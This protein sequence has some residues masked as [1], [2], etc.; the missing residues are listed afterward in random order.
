MKMIETLI[1][2]RYDSRYS[3]SSS[4]MYL[5]MM[6][7]NHYDFYW[8]KFHSLVIIFT[9]WCSLSFTSN[10]IGA[11]SQARRSLECRD[12]AV[13]LDCR[14]GFVAIYPNEIMQLLWCN[15][16]LR[17]AT[18]K[19]NNGRRCQSGWRCTRLWRTAAVG[20]RHLKR[21]GESRPVN[22]APRDRGV[23]EVRRDGTMPSEL[24]EEECRH[25]APIFSRAASRRDD[26]R[27]LTIRPIATPAA[28]RTRCLKSIDRLWVIRK[29]LPF[30]ILTKPALNGIKNFHALNFQRSRRTRD[31]PSI[32]SSLF[33]F[34]TGTML[35]R[36]ALYIERKA[37]TCAVNDKICT[38][39]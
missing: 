5:N 20:E 24:S 18:D 33:A 2:T 14:D 17:E 37:D 34:R 25:A 26:K 13:S 15:V 6:C 1:I 28:P 8:V 23:I 29:V 35:T 31:L 16:T 27:R 38:A 32:L 7:K 19:K 39:I 36:I 22:C 3:R 11:N 12:H 21:A 9:C 30:R 4:D 10:Y